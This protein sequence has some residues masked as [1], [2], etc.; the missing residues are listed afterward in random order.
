MLVRWIILGRPWEFDL[1]PTQW[2]VCGRSCYSGW[3]KANVITLTL[4]QNKII[5]YNEKNTGKSLLMFFDKIVLMNCAGVSRIVNKNILK[6]L[7]LRKI[8]KKWRKFS[9][10]NYY[11]L[12]KLK[13][14]ILSS[15]MINCLIIYHNA[16]S[17]INL[18]NRFHYRPSIRINKHY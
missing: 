8:S 14:I 18:A 13:W 2:W 7:K 11:S 1:I 12:K 9:I 5:I 4:H 6:Y 17:R 3:S 16:L 10:N 15:P